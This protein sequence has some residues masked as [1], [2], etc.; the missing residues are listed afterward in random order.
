MKP[1]IPLFF[2]LMAALPF[3]DP[4]PSPLS[5]PEIL[6]VGT[7]AAEGLFVVAFDREREAFDVV[8]Q[9]DGR[10][11]PSF[12]ALHPTRRYLYSASAEASAHRADEGSVAAFQID[13]AS[14]MLS[15]LNEAPSA[16]SGACHVSVHPSGE[17]LYVSNY[18]SGS[19]GVFRVA[20]DGGV[21]DLLQRLDFA[22]SSVNPNRQRGPHTH[23]SVPSPDGRFVYVADLGADRIYVYAVNATNGLLIPAEPAYVSAHPGAGPRH[24]AVTGSRLYA[25]EELLSQIAVY[26]RDP[27]SGGLQLIERV[28]MLPDG[29]E[30]ENTAAEVQLSPDGRF[31]YATNRGHDSVAAYEIDSETGRLSPL[32]QTS[33]E[34]GHPRHFRIDPAGDFVWVAN[35][36]ADQVRLF[37]RDPASGG[38]EDTETAVTIPKPVSVTYLRINSR[39]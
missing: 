34:G 39:P 8:Q 6:Y 17:F 16:G 31:L 32:G 11:Q 18:G 24:L 15:P 25:V 37:R 36:D 38:L 21:G 12:Q 5:G 30:G 26:A 23:S 10:G 22:G 1:F 28:P 19:L 9:L 13:P 35:R 20:V 33:T 7:F 14:G 4:S 29:F 2:L 27:Q 3:S